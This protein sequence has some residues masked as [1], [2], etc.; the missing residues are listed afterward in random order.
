MTERND[1]GAAGGDSTSGDSTGGDSTWSRARSFVRDYTGGVS[2]RDLK[3]LFDRDASEAWDVLTRDHQAGREPEKG[4][5]RF[6][7]RVRIFF[8]GLTSK[9]TPPRRILFAVALLF[10]LLGACNGVAVDFGDSGAQ[11]SVEPR[12]FFF[13]LSIGCLIYLL[14]LELVDRVR[15][16]DELEIARQLQRELLPHGAPEIAGLTFAHAYRTANEVGGDYYDFVPLDDGR[17]ALVIGD[18]SGHGMAAGLLMAIASSTLHTAIDLDPR[19]D[20]VAAI[21]NRALCRAGD[22]RA[23]MTL[24]YAL[25][26]PANGK[27]DYVCAGHPFPLLRRADGAV[28]E[29]GDGG[30]PLGMRPEIE[31][32]LGH[33]ELAPGDVLLLYTDGLPEAVGPDDRAFGFERLRALVT[34]AGDA[35]TLRDRILHAFDGHRGDRPLDDDLSLVVVKRQGVGEGRVVVPPPPVPPV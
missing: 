32:P 13:T 10:V 34:A 21:L 3:R 28:E 31:A 24:F 19:P 5:A 27:L 7:F 22:R 14:A 8:L 23:F 9:L 26:D 20:R 1:G 15:V 4:V 6:F 18:A 35:E 16:R 12:P 17:L 30:L 11:F 25:L 33:A 2:S 29:L